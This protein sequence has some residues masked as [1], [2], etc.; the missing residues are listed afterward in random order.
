M[1]RKCELSALQQSLHRSTA[2]NALCN[3]FSRPF[4]RHTL[5][6][7]SPAFCPVPERKRSF[8]KGQVLS[9]HFKLR[10]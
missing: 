5:Q 3:A 8:E 10:S 9:P 7:K 2:K 4:P 6:E 1:R